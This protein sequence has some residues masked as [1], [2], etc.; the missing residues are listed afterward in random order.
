MHDAL[1]LET[2]AEKMGRRA[3]G[4]LVWAVCLFLIVAVLS[5]CAGRV[6]DGHCA[7]GAVGT[8]DSGVPVVRVRCVPEPQ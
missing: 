5:G 1:H 8:T 3:M 6:F 7:I 4:W 2:P